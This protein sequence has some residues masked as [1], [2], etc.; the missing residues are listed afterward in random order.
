MSS[1][2]Q[3]VLQGFV[4]SDPQRRDGEP[5]ASIC[6]FV[7]SAGEALGKT[8]WMKVVTWGELALW[9]GKYLKK[10]MCV[11]VEG[12]FTKREFDGGRGLKKSEIEVFGEE[13]K[14]IV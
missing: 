14:L 12:K 3:V 10:G 5:G 9:C 7:M 13:L 11:R 8:L 4:G 2:N 1:F 6:T